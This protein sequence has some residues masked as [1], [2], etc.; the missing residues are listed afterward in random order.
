MRRGAHR[1]GLLNAYVP[2][3]SLKHHLDES[4]FRLGYLLRLLHGYGSSQVL[5]ETLL[6][7][8]IEVPAHYRERRS[9]YRLLIQE[10]RR[11]GKESLAFGLGIAAYHWSVRKAYLEQE[12][13]DLPR[14]G[15]MGGAIGPPPATPA[16]TPP[17][18][19]APTTQPPIP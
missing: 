3:L 8:K 19:P 15:G 9:F 12:R 10:F 1:L 2:Q 7:G 6:R 13:G 4:R 16:L 18:H 17:F 11:A 5:L 14:R